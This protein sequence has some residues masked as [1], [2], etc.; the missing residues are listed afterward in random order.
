[1]DNKEIAR[2]LDDIARLLEVR[3]DS[4]FKIRAYHNA[5]RSIA[6]YPVQLHEIVADDGDLRDI[7]GVGEAIA[8]KATEFLTTGRLEYYE[9]LRQSLPAGLLELMQVPGIGPKTAGR[10]VS[11][12]G[13]SSIG[14]L[15]AA[16]RSGGL[17]GLRGLGEKTAEKWLEEIEAHRHAA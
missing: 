3:H 15:E 10:L 2:V 16:L 1:M 8:A 14:E 17:V 6:S 11:E 4:P 5:A 13:I 9:K 7:P 12:L